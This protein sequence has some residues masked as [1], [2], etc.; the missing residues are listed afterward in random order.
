MRDLICD[1]SCCAWRAN[2]R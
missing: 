2:L 1:V